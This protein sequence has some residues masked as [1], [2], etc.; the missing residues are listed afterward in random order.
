MVHFVGA[1]PGAADLITIRGY[2]L[3]KNTDCVIYT[4]SLINKEILNYTKKD[5]KLYNSANMTLDE[6]INIICENEKNG[7]DTVRLHTGDSSI[8]GAVREQFERLKENKID[9]DVTAGVSSFLAAAASLKTE[10]TV[11]NVSQ[12]IIITRMEGRTAVPPKES[13]EELSK[14]NATMIVFL[15][16]DKIEKLVEKLKIGY[17]ENTPVAVVYKASWKNEKIIKGNIEN[18]SEKVKQNN[19]KKTALVIV[20]N[21]MGDYYELSKLYDKNFSHSYR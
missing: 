7:L 16:I 15:S 6:I 4:G 17:D 8:Y 14:H 12:S 18:I 9:F 11:P 1:G 19:I 3:L 10:Y 5:C 21:F 13:I 20:G 2:N